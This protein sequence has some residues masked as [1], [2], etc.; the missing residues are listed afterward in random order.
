MGSGGYDDRTFHPLNVS[1]GGGFGAA[2]S[3][4][5]LAVSCPLLTFRTPLNSVDP[6]VLGVLSVGD[7]LQIAERN[8][9]VL[10]E[11]DDGSIA[12]SITAPQL[13]NLLACIAG[14][15][16][17]VAIVESIHGGTCIVQIKHRKQ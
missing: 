11:T 14:G 10:A 9:S 2:S 7:E 3:S 15:Y 4:S 8:G 16:K 13:S 17:Y 1:G 6:K 5:D 12:G